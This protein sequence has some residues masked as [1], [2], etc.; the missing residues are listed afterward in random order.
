M[1]SRDR[2]IRVLQHERPDRTPIYAWVKFTLGPQ[3]EDL[4]GSVEAFEDHYEFDFAHIFG[5]PSPFPESAVVALREANGGRIGLPAALDLPLND[6]GAMED[7]R[8]I[9]DEIRHHKIERGR[10]V[11]VQ[12]PG[13][14]E[15][16]SNLVTLE[17]HLR[18]LLEYPEELRELYRRLTEWSCAFAR[19][20]L[21][22]GIDMIFVADD[23]GAQNT[24]LFSESIWRE[25]IYPSHRTLVE[26]V[27]RAG[28][29]IGLHSDGNVEAVVDG[30]VELGYDLV[31]PWQESAGMN[32][33]S[34]KKRYGG[35]FVVMGGLDVQSTLGFGNLRRVES[36]I[37]RVLKLF[38][39]GGLLF[40]TSHFVQDHCS[41]EELIF[42]YD[43][44][45]RRVR[46]LGR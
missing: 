31:H 25:A 15:I 30:I 33:A 2:V 37:E 9:I 10:F 44:V 42:A 34:Q 11:Y 38:P 29:Y 18:G 1:L 16:V 24:L 35:Q 41:I 28:G 6:P 36:E 43:V 19:H 5:G 22:L 3:I 17:T 7:Y 20:C 40:C 26:A 21:E 23:W 45:Y 32:L 46:E 8:G 14:F 39:D 27:R 13:N 12:T 4:F